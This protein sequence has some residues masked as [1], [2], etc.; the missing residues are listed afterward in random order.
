MM[1]EFKTD[2]MIIEDMNIEIIM[3][4][5][6]NIMVIEIIIFNQII[7]LETINFQFFPRRTKS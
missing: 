6:E 4:G 3:N 1:K 2:N 5:M 7:I